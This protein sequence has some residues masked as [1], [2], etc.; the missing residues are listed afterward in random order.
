M[1]TERPV[2]YGGGAILN[3]GAGNF[4]SAAAPDGKASKLHWEG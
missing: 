2:P 1:T 3:E 4:T